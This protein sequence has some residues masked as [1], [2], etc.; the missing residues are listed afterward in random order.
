MK[1]YL[2]PILILIIVGLLFTKSCNKPQ[3]V[4]V[5]NSPLLEK[6]DSLTLEYVTIKQNADQWETAYEQQKAR[7]DSIIIKTKL[8][9]ITIVDS[10]TNDSIKCLPEEDVNNLVDSF[11]YIISVADSTI[12]LKNSQILNLEE[13]QELCDTII[14]NFEHNEEVLKETLKV[15]K[16]KKWK[17]AAGGVGIG[18]ILGTFYK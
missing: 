9:Y 16:R 14:S 4:I 3:E 5:D 10:S 7:K 8:K 18:F 12:S 11:E 6:I 15:E 1:N 13:R 2:V 17:F